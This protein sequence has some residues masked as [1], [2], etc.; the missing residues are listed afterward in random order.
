MFGIVLEEIEDGQLEGRLT[1]REEAL[2]A[3]RA[4]LSAPSP[5]R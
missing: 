1:T 3:A 5:A 2:S 4:R